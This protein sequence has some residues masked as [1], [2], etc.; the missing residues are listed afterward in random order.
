MNMG[1]NSTST[2]SDNTSSR[3]T[4]EMAMQDLQKSSCLSLENILDLSHSDLNCLCEEI[5][6]WCVYGNRDPQKLR[7]ALSTLNS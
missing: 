7:T 2:D 6:Y 5:K 3:Y 4:Y 1:E